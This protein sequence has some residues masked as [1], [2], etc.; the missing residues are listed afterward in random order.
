M[1]W[2]IVV[3]SMIAAACLTLGAIYGLVWHRNRASWAHLL[4]AMTAASTAAFT[5]CELRQT[6]AATPGELLSAMRWTHVALLFLLVST[7]WFVTLYLRAGRRWLAWTVSG[8]RVFYLLAAFLI[9]GNVD[10]L[11]IT[12]LRRVPFLADFVTVFE[13]IKNPWTL[14][15][16]ATMLALL[17]FVADASVTAWRR[18][19]RRKALMVGGTVEFFLLLG[20]VQA[21]LVHWAQLPIPVLISPLYLGLVAVMGYELSRDVL[22]ASQLLRELQVS[23]A[24]LRESEARSSAILRAVPDLMF[25]QTKDGV[26]LDWHAAD[27]GQLLLPPEQFLGR[28]MR[29]VL[30]P[31]LLREIEPAFAQASATAEPVG[32]E[33]DMDLA[34]GNR[35]FEARL[36]RA[37]NDQILTLVRD[38]TEHRRAEAALRE[39]AQRY[40]LATTAGAVGVWDRNLDTNDLYVDA[41]LKA[42]LGFQDAEIPNRVEYWRVQVHPEDV[43]VMTLPRASI[44]IDTDVYE[45]EQRMVH[46]DGSL[47]WFLSHGSVM[48]RADGTPYRMVGTFVDITERKL[49]ADQFRL[50]L[51]ATTTG[52]L[53]VNRTGRIVL[54]NT[55]VEKLF[56]YRREE[57][58]NEPVEMLVPERLREGLQWDG[59]TLPTRASHELSGVRRDGSEI[60]LEIGFSPLRTSEGEF[61][62]CSMA[63][64]TER[65]QAE[66]EREDLTRHLRDLAGRLIAAQEVERARLARD[67]HDDV[68]QQLAALSIALSSLRRRAAASP[69]GT[70]LQDDI[71]T[72]QQRASTLAESVRSLSHDLHP[73]VLRHVGLT[74]SLI[75]YCN[76]LSQSQQFAI[77]CATQGDFSSIDPG[78]ALCLYRIAQEALHNVVKHAHAR[79]VGVQLLRTGDSAELT[80]VDDGMGFDIET[81]K[82]GPGL[83][84]VS[85]TERARLSGGT[86]SIVT[87]LNQGTQ[88]RVEVPI[89]AGTTMDARDLSGRF[90]TST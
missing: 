48:R 66:R 10:Y 12:S 70:D 50:A 84:L 35:R 31:A 51:E 46:K 32:I 19:E 9:W 3:W 68:S 16:Y 62:L 78:A 6:Q 34:Q 73:D 18:G 52:M 56:G 85:I 80:I 81:G 59:G 64:I 21:A 20:T 8:L 22:R 55:H 4:F 74:A 69:A 87:A 79:H 38:V 82:S 25:L 28:H 27:P 37:S 67:L 76:G 83:G 13:G 58:I 42:I 39:S 30:P 36:L 88:V 7:T 61:V 86:A 49:S 47:R 53:M 60:P 44:P 26:Y 54:V 57:L 11:E 43:E 72:L 1:S 41:T 15:G 40:A 63:D 17:V 14:F 24:G 90:A 33:Y 77:D 71:A 89:N 23:E 75:A 29:D 5:L 2:F 45:A 65:K